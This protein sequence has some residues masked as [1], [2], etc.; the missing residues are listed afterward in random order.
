MILGFLG[1]GGSGKSTLST[2]VTEYLQKDSSN[3]VLAIDAD[4]NMDL[5]HNLGGSDDFPFLGDT[6]RLEL[7]KTLGVDPEMT[8]ANMVMN[9]ENLGKLRLNPVDTFTNTYGKKIRENLRLM[10]VGPHTEKV[11]QEKMCSHGLGAM[12]KAYLPLLGLKENEY[13]IVDEKAGVDSVGTG[14]PSGFTMSII[15]VEP[16]VYGIK[17][18]KQISSLLEN[19]YHLP[20]AYVINKVKEETDIEAVYKELEKNIIGHI[21]FGERI[22]DMYAEKI[23]TYAKAYMREKGDLR[24]AQSVSKFK[25][26]MI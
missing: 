8:Y 7:K 5:L 16:T 14:T 2:A 9:K 13:V 15:V 25:R 10:A 12:L 21:P 17:A 1:K 6:A 23:V 4:Y 22:D 11:L 19:E 24:H 26:N 18:A 20:F 3:S